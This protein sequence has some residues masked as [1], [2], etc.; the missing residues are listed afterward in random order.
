[1]II[2]ARKI[3]RIRRHIGF[4]ISS[5]KLYKSYVSYLMYRKIT[6]IYY[7]GGKFTFLIEKFQNLLIILPTMLSIIIIDTNSLLLTYNNTQKIIM[8]NLTN[9]HFL[10]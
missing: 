4:N 10:L 9:L 8:N 6:E 5:K 7:T 2:R 3:Q 1:M